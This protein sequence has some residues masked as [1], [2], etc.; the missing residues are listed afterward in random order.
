MESIEK[1]QVKTTVPDLDVDFCVMLD[2]TGSMGSYIEMSRNK[3]KDIIKQVK[4]QYSKSKVRVAIVAYRDV[5]DNNRFEVFKFSE[6]VDKAKTFLDG[7][8]ADGGGDTPEDVNGGFQKVLYELDWKNPV[9]TLFHVADAPCHGKKFHDCDD[10][11]PDGHMSD[12]PW[13]QI[14]SDLVEK[15]IDYSFL[16]ITSSTDKMFELFKQMVNEFGPD[17]ID[18]TQET[19][20][21]PV[22]SNY[23]EEDFLCDYKCEK[24]MFCAT[25]REDLAMDLCNE[26]E[27]SVPVRS[28]E[29]KE[30]AETAYANIITSKISASYAKKVE[31]VITRDT[32][33]KPEIESETKTG[34]M[35]KISSIFK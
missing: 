31:K 33:V 28:K 24:M 3:I 17:D 34:F 32:A 35:S 8:V 14:F 21:V 25:E 23:L 9:R 1:E 10:D 15:G 7:L 29:L 6:D 12:K 30:C 11:H 16:K 26:D 19:L 18:F 20:D 4:E 13:K 22:G 27:R 5:Q 2:C